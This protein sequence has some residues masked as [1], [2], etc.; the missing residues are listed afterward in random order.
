MP[1][2]TAVIFD[3]YETLVRDRN[4]SWRQSFAAIIE[5][6]CLAATAEAL[7]ERWRLVNEDFRLTRTDPSLP[8]RTYRDTWQEAFHRAFDFMG[9]DG[10][11]IAATDHF[12]SDLSRREPYPEANEAVRAVQGRYR[13]ALLSNADNGYLLPNLALLD[14]EFERVVSSETAR[15]YKPMPELFQRMLGELSV[16]PEEALYVGDRFF[17]DVHGA[18][19]AGMNAVWINRHQQPRDP[20]LTIPYHEISNLLELPALLGGALQ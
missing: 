1:T 15:V 3:M 18:S 8:F 13:T 10:D 11:S 12:F 7:W 4:D 6:Q 14:V 16:A 9:L 17:E 2:I 19:Q 5:E 20:D